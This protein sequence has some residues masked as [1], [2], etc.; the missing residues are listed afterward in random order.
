MNENVGSPPSG[1]TLLPYGNSR[2][3]DSRAA[4]VTRSLNGWK[5]DPVKSS[6][7][8]WTVL[9]ALGTVTSA[10]GRIIHPRRGSARLSSLPS[11]LARVRVLLSRSRPS[12]SIKAGFCRLR[13]SNRLTSP[14]ET[15]PKRYS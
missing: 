3:A 5:A 4:S 1:G 6:R 10:A 7:K 2:P 8:N 15:S 12:E 9:S 14:A 13:S 11:A